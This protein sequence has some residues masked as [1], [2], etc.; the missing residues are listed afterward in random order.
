MKR[1]LLAIAL[2]AGTAEAQVTQTIVQHVP[3]GVDTAAFASG[4][5]IGSTTAGAAKQ[6][7][8]KILQGSKGRAEIRG[9]TILDQDTQL[10][11]ID[12]V[13]FSADPSATTITGNAAASIAAAD[14]AKVTAVIPLTTHKG[15]SDSGVTQA[16]GI[17]YLVESKSGDGT[18]YYALVARGAVDYAS[19]TPITVA[20]EMFVEK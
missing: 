8:T 12:F 10:L 18:L 20:I 4:D 14:V 13:L 11:D 9:V 2:L 15:Y 3:T 19:A 16:K 17:S 1:I 7:L 5:W 6:T